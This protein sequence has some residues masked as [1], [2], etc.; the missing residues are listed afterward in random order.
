MCATAVYEVAFGYEQRVDAFAESLG[1]LTAVVVEGTV[2]VVPFAGNAALAAA[3]VRAALSTP[4][5]R[6]GDRRSRAV[7]YAAWVLDIQAG[8][9][10]W[11]AGLGI[12]TLNTRDFEQI[13]DVLPGPR[14]EVVGAPF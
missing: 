14:L 12:A 7:R 5:A 3:A 2:N 8:A 9:S 1:V 10:A 13:A 6:R 11:A 4:P